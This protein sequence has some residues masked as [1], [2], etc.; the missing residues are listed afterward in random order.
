MA[1]RLMAD[2]PALRQQF[3][4]ALA[5]DASFAADPQARLQWWFE[6]SKYQPKATGRYPIVR[7]WDKTWK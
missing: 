3:N 6:H 4:D 1:R 5:A 7:V 2:S